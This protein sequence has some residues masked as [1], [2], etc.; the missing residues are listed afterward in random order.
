V[1]S[2]LVA[3]R[4]SA[5]ERPLWAI[6]NRVAGRWNAAGDPPVQYL[7]LHPMGPWAEILRHL[8]RRTAEAARS[9]RV[10][11]WVLRVALAE[12][13]RPVTFASAG[14]VGLR[15]QDLVADDQRPCRAAAARLRAEGVGA[16]VAPSAA[17]PGTEVLVLFG[18][19]VVVGYDQAPLDPGLDVPAALLQQDGRAPEGLWELVHHR[20]GGRRHQ[21]LRAFRAGT[22]HRFAQPPV[23]AAGLLG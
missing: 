1:S 23:T 2:D 12:P 16:I 8:G 17:L 15:A 7:A 19:R 9:L 5:Y 13:P 10:P 21:A 18:P 20:G 22:V 14:E 3:F 6:P 11:T 4:A